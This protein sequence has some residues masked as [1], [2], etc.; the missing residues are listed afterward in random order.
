MHVWH[1]W[2]GNVSG[3]SRKKCAKLGVFVTF[4]LDVQVVPSLFIP[5][6]AAGDRDDGHEPA[7][8]ALTALSSLCHM[9]AA[10]AAAAAAVIGS[11]V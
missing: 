10:A 6:Q 8:S 5:M 9:L 7:L 11:G 2:H 3:M 4:V 1:R